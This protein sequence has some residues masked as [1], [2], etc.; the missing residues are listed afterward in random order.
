MG[1]TRT[2]TIKESL[3]ELDAFKSAVK[4][5]QSSQQLQALRLI[6]SG[7][8]ATLKDVASHVGVH[9]TTVQ[10]WIKRYKEEGIERLL[11]PL[12]R[13]KP[14]KFITA[15]IHKILEARLRD[16]NNPFSGYVE[17]QEWLEKHH[18]VKIGYKWLW[19]Y[20]TTKMNSR[21]KVPRKTHIKK[22]P[23]AQESFFKTP[24]CIISN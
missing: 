22:A 11:M 13:N 5:F 17:V 19:K 1:R 16:K 12:T 23:D 8:Y 2:F 10:R 7:N 15:E 20:M 18:G 4:D 6:K 9:Y 3:E 21:L 14:S 24:L